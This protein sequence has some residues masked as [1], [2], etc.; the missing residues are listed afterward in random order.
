MW[1]RKG[2]TTYVSFTNKG[3]L[4]SFQ[5][6]QSKHGLQQDDFFRFVQFWDYYNKVF[7]FR[8]LSPTKLNFYSIMNAVFRSTL[9][10]T[11]SKSYEALI[12]ARS[13]NTLHIK[14]KW[15]KEAG[16]RHLKRHS[17]QPAPTMERTLL[18][19]HN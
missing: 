2:L 18:E 8:D 9:K 6:L 14:E 12:S 11:I 17:P 5:H 7:Q 3:A 4:Q 10:K 1:T 19:E 13:K 16:V 15:E